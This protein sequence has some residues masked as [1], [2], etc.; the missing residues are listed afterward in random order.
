M[1][2]TTSTGPASSGI[3]L[4]DS[5]QQA[6]SFTRSPPAR[7]KTGIP[8]GAQDQPTETAV[9]LKKLAYLENISER[10]TNSIS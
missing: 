10:I 2:A 9:R 6:I 3:N 7:G 1:I 5:T 4:K 8:A